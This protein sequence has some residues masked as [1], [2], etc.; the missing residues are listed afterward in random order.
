MIKNI[1][2]VVIFHQVFCVLTRG[3]PLKKKNT[4]V[5]REISGPRP[6]DGHASGE[7]PA[8]RAEDHNLTVI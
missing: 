1:L 6:S 4:T 8:G 5:A 7:G 3:Q 2:Q